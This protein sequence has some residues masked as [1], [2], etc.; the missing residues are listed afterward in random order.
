MRK[1]DFDDS[2]KQIDSKWKPPGTL[3]DSF[4]TPDGRY[5]I[6]KGS[7]A[8]PAVKQLNTRIRILVP[9]FIEGGSYIGQK[10]GEESPQ[11]DLSDA[12]RW[13]VFFLYRKDTLA[14]DPTKSSYIFMGYSTIYRFYW[15]QPTPPASPAEGWELPSGNLDLAELP[16]RTRL[17]Q[18]VILPPFQGKGH[19][20]RLYKSIFSHYHKHPQT[21]EFTVEDPNEAF[22]DLRDICDLAFLRTWPEFNALRL[23]TG[24]TI[25]KSG[26]LP[27]LIEGAD[28]LR[29]LQQKSKIASRQFG[30]V[31]EMHLMSQLPDSVRQTMDLD[32]DVPA[33]SAAD[34]HQE[35]IWQL[36]AKQR[37]YRHN[38]DALSELDQGERIEKLSDALASVELGHARLLAAFDRHMEHESPTSSPE[39]GKRKAD[40]GVEESVSKKA[41]VE[42]A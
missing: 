11:L 12:D 36:I 24:V 7:L 5:E 37:L 34:K 18:F 16:C 4:D 21:Q 25:P 13:T 40:V 26:P 41:R 29:A 9:L 28:Q 1:G 30:R 35:R 10:E 6:W 15:F 33:P 31:V 19:G 27:S 17:S 38:R 3:H 14:D 8:D 32:K 20:A 2:A 23:K 22:D 42:E 39:N